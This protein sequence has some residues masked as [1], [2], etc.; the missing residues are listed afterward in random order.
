MAGILVRTGKFRAEE[1]A[2]SGVR[3][4]WLLDSVADLPAALL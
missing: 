2:S 4:D 3:P 1:L